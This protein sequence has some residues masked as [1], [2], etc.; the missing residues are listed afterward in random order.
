L[1]QAREIESVDDTT[2]RRIDRRCGREGHH[3]QEQSG[4]PGWQSHA[5]FGLGLSSPPPELALL[6]PPLARE[7]APACALWASASL[8]FS[9]ARVLSSCAELSCDKRSLTLVVVSASCCCA[10]R[11]SSCCCAMT[12]R[13]CASRASASGRILPK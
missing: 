1:G 4:S 9:S 5:F 11:V 7:A 10:R 12:A 6:P 8:A 3:R 2:F 13:C